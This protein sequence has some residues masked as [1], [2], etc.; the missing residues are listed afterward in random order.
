[1]SLFKVVQFKAPKEGSLKEL[2]HDYLAPNFPRHKVFVSETLKD[3]NTLAYV[4]GSKAPLTMKRVRAKA[5][6]TLLLAAKS[7]NLATGELQSEDVVWNQQGLIVVSKAPGLPSQA[8][9]KAWEDTLCHQILLH[10][11]K[12]KS[13]PV[14]LPYLGM[15]H[16]LDR[17][18][19]GLLLFT[20]KPSENKAVSELFKGRNIKKTYSALVEGDCSQSQWSNRLN[21]CRGKSPKHK[22]YFSTSK[23]KGDEAH[24]RF[25]KLAT[26]KENLHWLRCSP[27]T[28]RT[29]QLRVHLQ[30]DGLGIV[31]DRVYGCRGKEDPMRL[32]AQTLEFLWKGEQVSISRSPDW[33]EQLPLL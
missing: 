4:S 10:F 21:I 26:L 25:E 12:E 22:F 19:S 11:L 33:P 6:V 9:F 32:H 29:H 27:V 8:T 13:F 28:G 18:T 15:H 2:S 17:D 3:T 5:P 7:E 31:G 16:R 24:S 1:V 14:R 23:T 20:T 30:S